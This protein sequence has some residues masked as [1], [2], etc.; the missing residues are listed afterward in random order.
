MLLKISKLKVSNFELLIARTIHMLLNYQS[1]WPPMVGS[2]NLA[3]NDLNPC[4]PVR[5]TPDSFGAGRR[6]RSTN[7]LVNK[8]RF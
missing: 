5:R 7:E 8:V 1:P 3:F 2:K 4:L 6:H